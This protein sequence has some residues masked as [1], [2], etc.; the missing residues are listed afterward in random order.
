MDAH[1]FLVAPAIVLGV[2]EV[3]QAGDVLALAGSHA[4]IDA[5]RALLVQARSEED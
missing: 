4:A 5:A 2:K 3:L 1:A